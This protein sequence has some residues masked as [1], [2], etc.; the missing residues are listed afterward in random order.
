ML[1]FWPQSRE[2]PIA[3]VHVEGTVDFL[4]RKHK[5]ESKFNVEEINQVV[6]KLVLLYSIQ[7][8]D[9]MFGNRLS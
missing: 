9:F 8:G 4:D 5:E 1:K 6:S 3:F 2:N 7:F